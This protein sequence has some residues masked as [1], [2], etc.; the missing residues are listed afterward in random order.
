MT[1]AFAVT[2]LAAAGQAPPQE[3]PT[4]KAAVVLRIEASDR[5]FRPGRKMPVRFAVENAAEESSRLDE[6]EDYLEG[7]EIGDATGRVFKAAGRTKG[8]TRR[9]VQVDGGGFIGRTVDVS[10]ALAVPEDREDWYTLRWS[11]GD[12]V[13]N[14]LR[15][16][17]VRDWIAEVDTNHGTIAF[18]LH[19]QTAPN[20]VLNFVR[21][22]RSGF[23]RESIFHRVIPGFMM[24]GGASKSEG[25]DLKPLDAEF[26]ATKHGFGTVSMARTDDINSATCQFFIC[27]GASPFLDGKYTA[28]G[29]VVRG[30]DVVREIEKAENDHN[31]C[32]G[33]GKAPDRPGGTACCGRPGHHSDRP[34]LDVVIKSISLVERPK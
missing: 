16:L 24:Q 13:S 6:P 22:A 3:S 10:S 12:S 27:F 5:A 8:I 14:D 15:V 9:S 4:P 2:L 7:L 1:F 30:E 33:C 28:F 20:H 34:A 29:Q 31:P 17:V 32:K 25:A 11:F 19:P 26:S 18:E 21:L 23:Y